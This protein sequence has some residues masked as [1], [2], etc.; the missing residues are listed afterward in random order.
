MC[1]DSGIVVTHS[2]IAGVSVMS[3]IPRINALRILQLINGDARQVA[4][5]GE[6]V[7]QFGEDLTHADLRYV[8]N[9][10][11]S[12]G[13]VFVRCKGV[14]K[15]II[16]GVYNNASS[17]AMMIGYNNPQNAGMNT[18]WNF[19]V[20]SNFLAGPFRAWIADCDASDSIEIYGHSAGGALAER[21]ARYARD[22]LPETKITLDTFAAPAAAQPGEVC[23]AFDVQRRRWMLH[24]DPVPMLPQWVDPLGIGGA[25][26]MAAS[27]RPGFRIEAQRLLE[28]RQPGRSILIDM[29]FPDGWAFS[30]NSVPPSE[31]AQKIANW[32]T[33]EGDERTLHDS[34]AYL[35]TFR[36][37]QRQG[38]PFPPAAPDPRRWE[39]VATATGVVAPPPVHHP[40]VVLPLAPPPDIVMPFILPWAPPAGVP[41]AGGITMI[42]I[43]IEPDG[44]V[45]GPDG[46]TSLAT[47]RR[48][49]PMAMT[50]LRPKKAFRLVKVGDNW[51]ACLNDVIVLQG[52]QRYKPAAF[53]RRGN[54][55][56]RAI[57]SRSLLYPTSLLAALSAWIAGAAAGG[58]FAS[59]PINIEL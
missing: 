18:R 1:Y 51:Q 54:A 36:S 20:E 17:L 34:S 2:L 19:S 12:K 37:L 59:P 3:W 11:V 46:S 58:D 32:I 15:I 47:I 31:A 50:K 38:R 26:A 9:G 27:V 53:V 33:G 55:F 45:A 6:L 40:N 44:R 48:N 28:F 41:S 5:V 25:L 4:I 35:T 29:R 23:N 39:L 14:V 7:E 52:T 8:V 56:L 57:G 10:G 24:G 21:V 43:T 13:A 16:A 49:D 30:R 22:V 42:P